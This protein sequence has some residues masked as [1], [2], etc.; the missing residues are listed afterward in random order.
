MCSYITDFWASKP[1]VHLGITSLHMPERHLGVDG[2]TAGHTEDLKVCVLTIG[3][4]H[5]QEKAFVYTTHNNPSET[6]VPVIL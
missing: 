4:V 1:C 6:P 5:L 3:F 2:V